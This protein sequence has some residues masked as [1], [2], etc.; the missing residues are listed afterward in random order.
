MTVA[1]GAYKQLKDTSFTTIF[2]VVCLSY[3]VYLT[4]VALYRLYIFPLAKFPG[5]KLAALS[6][7]YEFYYDVVLRGKFSGRIAELHEIYGE[8]ASANPTHP[9]AVGPIVRVT[10]WE[11]HVDDP[12]FYEVLFNKNPKSAKDPWFNTRF[13]NQTST[14]STCD[15][16]H[17]R[18]R[19]SALNP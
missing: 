10:P 8:D 16:A 7:W 3:G 18:L 13:G 2:A 14:F 11:L 17:H 6:K 1:I 4:A 12:S 5:P 9:N 15:A 19:R